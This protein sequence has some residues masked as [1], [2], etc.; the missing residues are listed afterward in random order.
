MKRQLSVVAFTLLALPGALGAQEVVY[1]VPVTGVI[2]L[3]IAPYIARSLKEAQEAGARAVIL[4]VNTLGG[5]VDAALN[6]VDA[7]RG[8]DIPVYALVD[9]RAISA[10]ALISVSTDSVFM[11]PEA[12]MGASTVV[13]GSGE[14]MSEKAQSVMRAQFRALAEAR[15]IDPRIGE[16]MVDEEIAIEGVIE[17]GKLLTL[18]AD[19]AVRVGYAVKVD[20]LD[21]VLGLLGLSGAEVYTPSVNWAEQVVRFLSHP[22][23]A[24]LLLSIGVLGLI[25]EI[26]TPS[27]GFAGLT[28]LLALTAFFGSHLIIGLAGLEEIILLAV[29]LVALIIEVFIVPGFGVAGVIAILSIG[30]AT[31]MA[32]IGSLPTWGD[33][34][35]A[36]G[37][38]AVAAGIVTAAFWVIVR[39]LPI[40]GRWKGVFLRTA[41]DAAAGYIVGDTRSD[42]IGAVG[43][44]LTDLRPAG[45]AKVN[46]ERLDV[47][48][49][50]GFVDRG[51][52]VCVIRSEAYRLVV[53]A[54]EE[55]PSP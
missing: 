33:V 28:G 17:A 22:V 43:V 27:F 35:R 12:L 30:A 23:V 31:F 24:P 50:G 26:K 48:A 1:R 21:A 39:Q 20:G 25:I 32:L 4:D 2:E 18:T 19:E 6:I 38:L 41:E 42:L 52:R 11:V 8:S 9:P 44:A 3:G 47:V 53:E 34:V 51:Q 5:R 10:G 7:V 49:E 55:S 16:A 37:I 15:G 54:I 45:S 40:S 29:G 46:G 13:G 36:S 14:K